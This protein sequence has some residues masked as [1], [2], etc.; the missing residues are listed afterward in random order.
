MYFADPYCAQQKV[1][2]ENSNGLLR[3]YYPKGMD[4]SKTNNTEL[5]EKLALFNNRP[6]KCINYKTPNELIIEY[7]T[8]CCT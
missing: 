1:T 6:R 4:L 3:E 8:Q 5:K 7:I 2:N